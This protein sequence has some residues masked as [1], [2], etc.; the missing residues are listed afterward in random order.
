[1]VHITPAA[2]APVANKHAADEGPADDLDK[3]L[4]RAAADLAPGARR[5]GPKL[6]GSGEEGQGQDRYVQLEEGH[7]YTFVTVGTESMGRVYAY[8]WDPAGERL[9]TDKPDS[10][11]SS[12]NFC[13]PT[14]GLYHFQGKPARGAGTFKTGIYVTR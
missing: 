6:T 5:H 14:T 3:R 8:L 13:A 10:T 12:F 7:C 2:P 9:V 11:V 1:M 4:A